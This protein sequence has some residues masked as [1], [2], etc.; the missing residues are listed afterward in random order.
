MRSEDPS[1]MQTRRIQSVVSANKLSW[2]QV[3]CFQE[4]SRGASDRLDI[5]LDAGGFHPDNSL[6]FCPVRLGYNI[7]D[8]LGGAAPFRMCSH[9]NQASVFHLQNMPWIEL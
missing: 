6:G 3:K 1:E 5:V 7:G 2:C 4:L 9:P 8:D